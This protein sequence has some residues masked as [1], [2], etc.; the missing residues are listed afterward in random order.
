MPRRRRKRHWPSATVPRQIGRN[1]VWDSSRPL[2]GTEVLSAS[3]HVSDSGHR[4][5]SIGSVKESTTSPDL[6]KCKNATTAENANAVDRPSSVHPSIRSVIRCA[7]ENQDLTK[8]TRFHIRRLSEQNNN[9]T[10]LVE[11]SALGTTFKRV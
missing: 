10:S 7:M 5:L 8:A 4:I 3:L 2:N 9:V 11:R 1:L 6:R